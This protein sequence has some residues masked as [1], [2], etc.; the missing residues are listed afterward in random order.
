[1]TSNSFGALRVPAGASASEQD[2]EA[3]AYLKSLETPRAIVIP[4][5]NKHNYRRAWSKVSN[6][7]NALRLAEKLHE[8]YVLRQRHEFRYIGHRVASHLRMALGSARLRKSYTPLNALQA[9]VYYPL[10]VPADVALTVR[11]PMYLDQLV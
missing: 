9:F 1:M 5:K 6:A 4:L 2:P 8:K 11:A 3:L 7:R 10:Y